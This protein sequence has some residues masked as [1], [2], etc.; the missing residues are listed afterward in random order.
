MVK[1]KPHP[2][3]GILIV[4]AHQEVIICEIGAPEFAR[5]ILFLASLLNVVI[6]TFDHFYRS[7]LTITLILTIL[8]QV[9]LNSEESA[10][11]IIVIFVSNM[12]PEI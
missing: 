3:V 11:I 10:I 9:Q 8:E 2:G 5:V 7:L 4:I 6:F 1:N 12:N